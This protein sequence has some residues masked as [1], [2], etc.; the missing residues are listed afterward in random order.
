M[1]TACV[2]DHDDISTLAF[3]IEGLKRVLAHGADATLDGATLPPGLPD[4]VINL[5]NLWHPV[6]RLRRPLADLF[7][8]PC[9]PMY[10][11]AQRSRILIYLRRH[12]RAVRGWIHVLLGQGGDDPW[13][14][15]RAR[16][17]EV[18]LRTDL[19]SDQVLVLRAVQTLTMLDV[20]HNCE[21]VWSLGGYTRLATETGCGDGPPP[22]PFATVSPASAVRGDLS[23]RRMIGPEVA[24]PG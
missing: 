2:L 11:Q 5:R 10:D 20:Q 19:W 3:S 23:D 8:M 7:A 13:A 6:P 15:V 12:R 4:P 1:V 14:T 17:R 16:M 24:V 9:F 21:L 22:A 18:F